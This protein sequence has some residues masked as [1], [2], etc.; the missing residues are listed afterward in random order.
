MEEE[1]LLFKIA[2]VF[3]IAGIGTVITAQILNEIEVNDK[4]IIASE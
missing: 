3:N 2:D 4:V 1:S